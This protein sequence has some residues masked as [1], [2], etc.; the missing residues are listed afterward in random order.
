MNKDPGQRFESAGQFAR[1]LR[2]HTVPVGAGS[3]VMLPGAG[4]VVPAAGTSG[5]V[6]A[7]PPVQQAAPAAAA[8]RRTGLLIGL[9]AAAAVVVIGIVVGIIAMTR[10]GDK[11][12][13]DTRSPGNGAGSTA[14]Q[15]IVPPAA[16]RAGGWASE[17][18]GSPADPSPTPPKAPPPSA[19]GNSSARDMPA[20][21][22]PAPP[23]PGPVQQAKPS[24]PVG[25]PPSPA[26]VA[27]TSDPAP[28]GMLQATDTDALNKLATDGS[29]KARAAVEGV[30]SNVAG[31][32]SGK[33]YYVDFK[34]VN[35]TRGF[36]AFFYPQQLAKLTEA[37]PG[38][39]DLPALKGKRV[40]VTGEVMIYQGRPEI[41]IRSPDQVKVVE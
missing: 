30:V 27:G 36:V 10:G 24:T 21:P 32:R 3:A 6:A 28:A 25:P 22:A 4:G 38:A 17:N 9:A 1:V 19:P 37:F 40:R 18:S 20:P 39:G 15:S 13:A 14:G 5:S 34:G 23:R 31:A 2:V 11:A 41:Q 33:V 7:L 35:S 8:P 26:P 29:G 16:P 12:T